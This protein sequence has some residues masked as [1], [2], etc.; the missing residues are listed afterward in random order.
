MIGGRDSVHQRLR[1]HAAYPCC[2]PMTV[3]R[4]C[5]QAPD[6]ITF[7]AL[8]DACCRALEVDRALELLQL[9]YRQLGQEPTSTTCTALLEACAKAGQLDRGLEVL[10]MM[11]A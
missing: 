6:S 5:D 4:C 10:Q 11:A 7:A 9:M 8:V 1:P 2:H 3:R